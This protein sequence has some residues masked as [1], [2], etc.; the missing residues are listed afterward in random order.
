MG[1]FSQMADGK[2][3]SNVTRLTGAIA[4]DNANRGQ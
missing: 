4:R 1:R 2:P 3:I